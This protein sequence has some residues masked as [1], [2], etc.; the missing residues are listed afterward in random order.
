MQCFAYR[1]DGSV[2]RRTHLKGQHQLECFPGRGKLVQ[3]GDGVLKL[4]GCRN[5][6]EGTQRKARL[7][8][9]IQVATGKVL[10][11]SE[12]EKRSAIVVWFSWHGSVLKV[13]AWADQRS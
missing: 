4:R 11:W 10:R 6:E 1:S 2:A 8:R 7:A 9:P 3:R 12:G 5:R 13:G